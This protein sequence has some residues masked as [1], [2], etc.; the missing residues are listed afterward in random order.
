MADF[1]T[2]YG[3][4]LK[5]TGECTTDDNTRNPIT[6]ELNSVDVSSWLDATDAD[7]LN[8][9]Y[10]WVADNI[11]TD[12]TGNFPGWLHSAG[13]TDNTVFIEGNDA[14]LN[15]GS[16]TY[17]IKVY[18]PKDASV[19]V[20]LEGGAGATDEN[21]LVTDLDVIGGTHIIVWKNNATFDDTFDSA[22][23]IHTVA[24]SGGLQDEYT[25]AEV[26]GQ[27]MDLSGEV[28]GTL[29]LTFRVKGAA[30][31]DIWI[32]FNKTITLDTS[33]PQFTLTAVGA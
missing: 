12:D 1:E 30:G 28:D 3:L 25:F 6:F 16:A 29:Y 5:I 19:A 21:L 18:D 23:V 15:D 31:S 32:E 14:A 8:N 17:V 7:G 20:V 22:K 33:H 24:D 27:N 11:D 13:G 9:D 4:G 26:E 2:T 10:L